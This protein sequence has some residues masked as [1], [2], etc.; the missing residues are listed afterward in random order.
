MHRKLISVLIMFIMVLSMSSTAIA[1]TIEVLNEPTQEELY[2]Y[3]KIWM[4]ATDEERY[5]MDTEIKARAVGLSTKEFKFFARVVE[6]EGRFCEDD[7][8]DKVLVA[9]VVINRTNC[10]KWTT[11]TITK[12]LQRPNQF[13]AVNQ[14]T[15]ECYVSRTLDSE[16]AIVLAYRLIDSYS[17]DCHMVYYNSIGFG[18]YSSSFAD[19]CD[20]R[21]CNG[22]CFSCIN[23]DCSYCTAYCAIYDPEWSLDSV[24]MIE[25]HYERPIGSITAGEIVYLGKY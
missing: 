12:T 7:L 16:W 23:C 1:D 8:T 25:P 13:L 10:S 18:G 21:Y 17:I 22:N 15:K 20:C 3:D 19:Y 24:E 2:T 5:Y 14:D 4:E 9:C 11:K 6:G